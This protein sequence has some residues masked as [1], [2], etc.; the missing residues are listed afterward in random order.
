MRN[1]TLI[2]RIHAAAGGVALTMIF[3]FLAASAAAEFA[4]DG[5]LLAQVKTSILFGLAVLVPA[6]ATSGA[7]G[8]ALA[9]GKPKGLA[10]A[11]LRRMRLVAVNGVLVLVPAAFFLAWKANA[12][13]YD[14]S[15]MGVQTLEFAAGLTNIALIGANFR[16]GLRMEKQRQTRDSLPPFGSPHRLS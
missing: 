11:K 14:Q 16:D 15:F 10:A 3:F 13:A 6:L 9:G 5:A 4:A 7:S 1:R 12:G 2:R 8:F